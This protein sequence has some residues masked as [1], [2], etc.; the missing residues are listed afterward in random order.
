MLSRWRPALRM[1]RRDL[2]RRKVRAVMTML[3][4]SL[5]VAVGVAAS[6]VVHNTGMQGEQWARG[7]MGG[8]DALVEVTPFAEVQAEFPGGR[9]LYGKPTRFTHDASGKRVPVRRPRASVIDLESLLPRGSR[10][11][12]AP[13]YRRAALSS[14]GAAELVFLAAADPMAAGLDGSDMSAGKAPTRPDEAAVTEPMAAEMGYL[15]ASGGLRADA[16]LLLADGPPLT[17]VGLLGTNSPYGDMTRARVLLSPTNGLNRRPASDYLVDLP[18]MSTLQTRAVVDLLD[19]H[20]VAMLPRDVILHPAAWGVRPPPAPPVDIKSLV[21]GALVV[22]FGLIEVVLIVGSAFAVGA[23]RQIRDLGLLSASGG[24]PADVR[25][26]VLAQGLVLGVFAA[27]LGAAAGFGLLLIGMP[28][29]EAVS[30]RTVWTR[31]VDWTS[32]VLVT[33]LGAFSGL[34]AAVFPAR[35]IGKLTPVAALSGRFPVRPGESV[36]HRPAFLLTAAGLIA[37]GI[38]GLWT[39]REFAPRPHTDFSG[40]SPLPPALGA[41]GLLLVVIGTVWLAPYVVRRVAALGR[42]LPL[43]ARFAFRDAGRHRFRTAA[44]AV[45]LM[46]TAAGTVLTGFL[47]NSAAA[48]NEADSALPRHSMLIYTRNAPKP[49]RDSDALLATVERVVGP[50]TTLSAYN[51]QGAGGPYLAIHDPDRRG[52]QHDLTVVDE[53]LLRYLVGTDNA[54]ALRTFRDGGVVT[55]NGSLVRAGTARVAVSRDT[56]RRRHS[57]SLLPATAVSLPHKTPGEFMRAWISPQTAASLGL[58]IRPSMALALTSNPVTSN[59]LARLAVYGID[60]RSDDM[61][62]HLWRRIILVAF[63]AAAALTVLV[64]GIAVALAAAEGR[65]DQAT[66][67]AVGAGPWRRRSLGAM[68]G[69]FLGLV[70]GMLGLVVSLPAGVALTQLDGL[71]GT[72]VPWLSVLATVLGVPLIGSLAGWAVTPTKLSLVRRTS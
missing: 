51:V 53:D 7:T 50:V 12:A 56:G 68:H 54:A 1:A 52:V 11:V 69:L 59:D 15:D 60:A 35:S 41:L 32:V 24:S 48:L 6:L 57:N 20:G 39:A 63:G 17:V 28:L 3:L 49:A 18:A 45:T 70:G 16:T 37:L 55:D 62:G 34:V 9:G 27:V 30:H 8:A 26:V 43:S 23:R 36:A 4:V 42:W 21:V 40:T 66:L 58:R 2:W 25:R 22:L 71:A 5:P 19:D 67:A 61:D 13:S 47:V 64:I 65:S 44:A 31:D 29:Y 10:V 46:I 38:S 14:G 33:S 72:T